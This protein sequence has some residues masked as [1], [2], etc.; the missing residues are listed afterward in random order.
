MQE[1]SSP[2]LARLA[3]WRR[4]LCT[5]SVQCIISYIEHDFSFLRLLNLLRIIISGILSPATE[6]PLIWKINPAFSEHTDLFGLDQLVS[7]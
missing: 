2:P 4:K 3:V 6:S 1:E 5:A 7:E